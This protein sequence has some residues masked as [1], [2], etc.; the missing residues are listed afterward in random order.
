MDIV[1]FSEF[2]S[3]QL[4]AFVKSMLQGFVKENIFNIN[5]Y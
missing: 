4:Y 1:K 2:F 5:Y 3:R